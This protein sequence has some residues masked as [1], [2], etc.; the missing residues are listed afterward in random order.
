MLPLLILNTFLSKQENTKA[1]QL[2][3]ELNI[4]ARQLQGDEGRRNTSKKTTTHF[5][6]GTN[7]T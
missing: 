7:Y 4:V 1:S 6:F 3:I 5:G 2:S